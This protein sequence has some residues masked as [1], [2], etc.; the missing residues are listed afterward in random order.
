MGEERE[1]QV[2]ASFAMHWRLAGFH[3]ELDSYGSGSAS[4]RPDFGILL[5]RTKEYL[6]LE[7]KLLWPGQGY[8]QAVT[9]LDKLNQMFEKDDK[10][11]GLLTV[12][13]AATRTHHKKFET[14][15]EMMSEQIAVTTLYE[16]VG[17]EKVSFDGIDER[18]PYAWVGMWVR[19]LTPED[20]TEHTP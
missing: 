16:Q 2:Q 1:V 19:R 4:R 18:F 12:G 8:Q 5:P 11:V 14:V 10:R 3:V 17:L 7:F 15:H 9:D 20:D 13:F 6:F